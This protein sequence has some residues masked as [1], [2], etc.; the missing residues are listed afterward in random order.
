[1][2]PEEHQMLADA[3]RFATATYQRTRD[4]QAKLVAL[5]LVVAAL[6]AGGVGATPAAIAKAVNDDAAKRLLS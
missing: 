2:T 4:L 3:L 6:P 1:M 5:D